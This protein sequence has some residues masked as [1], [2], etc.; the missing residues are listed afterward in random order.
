MLSFI[1]YI[2]SLHKI[3]ICYYYKHQY[4]LSSGNNK[5]VFNH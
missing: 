3:Q 1:A 2:Y 5:F 4:L